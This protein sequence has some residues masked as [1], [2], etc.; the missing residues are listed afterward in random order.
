LPYLPWGCAHGEVPAVTLACADT[1]EIAPLDDSVDSNVVHIRGGGTIRSF[2][3]APPILKRVL[4]DS[5]ITLIHS[6][7]L[8]LLSCMDRR[9]TT[10]SI[11]LY[12]SDGF[13]HWNEVHFTE[14]GA[15]EFSRRLDR[16]EARLEEIERRLA[17]CDRRGGRSDASC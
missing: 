15:R 10:A 8:Q 2:G 1:V 11:G 3:E 7:A 17:G 6:P 12:A 13:G 5:D 9:I 14:T 4:F 16:I